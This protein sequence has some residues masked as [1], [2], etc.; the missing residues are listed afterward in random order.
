MRRWSIPSEELELELL[1]LID[2][3]DEELKSLLPL[4]EKDSESDNAFG[5][6]ASGLASGS[7]AGF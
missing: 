1:L 7:A 3:P 2:E 4:D 6:A 5:F